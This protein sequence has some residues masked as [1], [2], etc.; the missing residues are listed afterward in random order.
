MS[1]NLNNITFI[2]VTYKSD[3]I[4]L[5]CLKSLPNDAKIIIIENSNNIKLKQNLENQFSNLSVILENNIGMGPANNKGIRLSKTEYVFVIN[6]DV[7]FHDNSINKLIDFAKKKNDF[8]ILAPTCD[9]T[10]YPNYKIGHNINNNDDQDY[11][12]VDSV[13]GYAMLFNKSRF[14]DNIYFDENFFLYLENDDLCFR[15]KKEGENIYVLKGAKINHLG[16]QSSSVIHKNE[17]EY[18]RNWHWMWSK[19]YFDKKHYGLIN[20]FSKIFLNLVS[21]I[22]KCIYYTIIFNTHKKNIYKMRVSGLINSILGKKS[23]YRP[24]I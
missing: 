7:R 5:N 1:L 6:P 11:L 4:I 17:I 2:I 20:A 23:W 9:D 13:D 21:A 24:K 14:K 18:S 15:K 8:A 16:G 12:K 3:E 22:F 19:F 10:K